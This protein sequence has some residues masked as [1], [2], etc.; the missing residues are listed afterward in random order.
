[1]NKNKKTKKMVSIVY[2][3]IQNNNNNTGNITTVSFILS[4]AFKKK[5]LKR[6]QR[7]LIEY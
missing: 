4:V 6:E 3:H 5:Y 2:K 7:S 1:M